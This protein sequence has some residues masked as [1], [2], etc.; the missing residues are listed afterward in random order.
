M[1]KEL[2]HPWVAK[3]LNPTEL[4]EYASFERNLE[5]RFTP[6]EAEASRQ[7]WLDL[8]KEV[9]ANLDKDPTSSLGI[10]IGKRC[11]EWVNTLF[12]QKHANL[13][14]T[15]WEKGF[16]GGHTEVPPEVVAWLDKAISEYHKR[17]IYAILKQA[18]TQPSEAVL[19]QWNELVVEICSTREE[20]D[21]L[22][23]AVFADDNISLTAKAWLKK[24]LQ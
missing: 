13:R 18:E 8:V 11:M 24:T 7:K 9:E 6:A 16:K 3:V 5:T 2:E 20:K 22:C 4:K 15:L 21:T 1:T 10:D 23:E 17:R 19:K 12:T 14:A